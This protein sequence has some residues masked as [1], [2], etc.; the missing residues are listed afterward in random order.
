MLTRVIA[1]ITLAGSELLLRDVEA[2]GYLDIELVY[3]LRQREPALGF[4]AMVRA[5][6]QSRLVDSD[7]SVNGSGRGPIAIARL[8][9]ANGC[10]ATTHDSGCGT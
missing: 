10:N 5:A 9:G 4:E 3:R 2:K 8:G 6:L 1:T 7:C